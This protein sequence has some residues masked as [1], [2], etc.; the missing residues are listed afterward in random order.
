MTLIFLLFTVIA[1]IISPNTNIDFFPDLGITENDTLYFATLESKNNYFANLSK[2]A[3]VANYSYNRRERGVLKVQLPMTTAFKIGYMRYKNTNFENFWF[4]AFV[5][6]VEYDN[7]ET[8][9][10]RFHIDVLTTYMGV[11]ELGQCFIERQHTISDGI[12]ENIA[13]EGLGTGE[14]VIEQEHRTGFFDKY[15]ISIIYLPQE[16]SEYKGGYYNGLYSGCAIEQYESAELANAAIDSFVQNNQLDSIIAIYMLPTHYTAKWSETEVTG[17]TLLFDK[18]YTSING[19]IPRNKKLFCYPYKFVDVY[20]SEGESTQY[21]YEFF[22]TLPDDVSS[23]KY[24]FLVYGAANANPQIVCAPQAYKNDNGDAGANW[25][26]QISMSHFAQCA[27]A[28]DSYKAYLA[29]VN[30]TFLHDSA[31][32]MATGVAM[33]WSSFEDQAPIYGAKMLRDITSILVDNVVRPKSP[34]TAKG[35]TV[36]DVGVAT[37]LK[38]FYFYEK[39]ITKSYAKMLDSYFDSFGYAVRQVGTPNMNA[40]PHWTYCKTIGCVVHGNLPADDARQIERMFDNGVR[41]WK[42]VDELGNYSLDNSPV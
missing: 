7:N 35:S 14:Y 30:S 28:I 2:L 24:S 12:G 8:A 33:A 9:I 26:E 32:T 31:K 18:P 4:Y 5:D 3:S 1:M 36:S 16:N 42:S 39:C 23:G 38:D 34:M 6:S 10:I 17:D 41:F 13:D 37:K 19:Y 22:N 11:F 21:M 20:N 25:E 40:R 15:S 29:Q 27:V